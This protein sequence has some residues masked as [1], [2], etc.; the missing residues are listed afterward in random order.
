[1]SGLL[2]DSKHPL[3]SPLLGRI[4]S[5]TLC[6][7]GHTVVEMDHEEWDDTWLACAVCG[8]RFVPLEAMA[9]DYEVVEI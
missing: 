7:M 4:T 2:Y 1:M 9:D 5:A 8:A 6:A 3:R